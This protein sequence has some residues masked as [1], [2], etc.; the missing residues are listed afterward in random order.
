MVKR[1]RVELSVTVVWTHLKQESNLIAAG[2][3]QKDFNTR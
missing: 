2:P 3:P 1:E